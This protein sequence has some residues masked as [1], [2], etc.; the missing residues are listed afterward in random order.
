MIPG[1]DYAL[2]QLGNICEECDLFERFTRLKEDKSESVYRSA[3]GKFL[4]G[5]DGRMVNP[6]TTFQIAGT[7]KHRKYRIEPSE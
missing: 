6:G 3:F 1:T 7:A 4:S 2:E 5:Y